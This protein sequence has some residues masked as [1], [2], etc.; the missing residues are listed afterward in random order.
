M[1]RN[2]HLYITKPVIKLVTLCSL[3]VLSF[4]FT[5]PASANS[6]EITP[7]LSAA[8]FT[9][10]A[11]YHPRARAAAKATAIK[12]HHPVVHHPAAAHRRYYRR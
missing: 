2:S 7:T 4:I 12:R 9:Q 11:Y 5:T 1:N 3:F 6:N 10:I 8:K